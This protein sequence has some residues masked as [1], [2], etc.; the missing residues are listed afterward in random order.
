MRHVA[1]LHKEV[2]AESFQI[3]AKF[4]SALRLKKKSHF[5]RGWGSFEV[6]V[7]LNVFLDFGFIWGSKIV[8]KLYIFEKMKV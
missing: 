8:Q 6:L 1:V 2:V 7:I 4:F 5:I 3:L